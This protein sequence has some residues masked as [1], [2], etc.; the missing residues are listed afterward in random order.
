MVE[1]VSKLVT[2]VAVEAGK[3]VATATSKGLSQIINDI[4][5][6]NWGYKWD[7]ERQKKEIEVTHN[8]EKFRTEIQK[9]QIIFQKKTA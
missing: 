6:A 2:S 1:P 7:E 3:E 9:N 8:V 4:V 5:Y